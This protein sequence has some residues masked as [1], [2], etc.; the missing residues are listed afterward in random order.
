MIEG[1]SQK[2]TR[3]VPRARA[4]YG[5]GSA[6]RADLRVSEPLLDLRV[7]G[8]MLVPAADSFALS[9]GNAARTIA[10]PTGVHVRTA[11]LTRP[12][13]HPL[14]AADHFADVVTPRALAIFDDFDAHIA[15]LIARLEPLVL[16]DDSAALRSLATCP[17]WCAD[18]TSRSGGAETGYAERSL[19]AVAAMDALHDGCSTME[20]RL[21]GIATTSL[22]HAKKLGM[23]LSL[24]HQ[25]ASVGRWDHA[26][27]AAL[28]VVERERTQEYRVC[29]D[30]I[31]FKSRLTR[32]ELVR[33]VLDGLHARSPELETRP[34]F[35]SF[36]LPTLRAVPETITLSG[37]LELSWPCAPHVPH[38]KLLFA[39]AGLQ[40]VDFQ[41]ATS[42]GPGYITFAL[43]T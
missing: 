38:W 4:G 31:V 9:A 17:Q 35:A 25:H 36:V 14:R 43:P 15:R 23:H 7:H 2:C 19:R 1:P 34:G 40:S 37:S 33:H 27:A 39:L 41:P 32:Y 6:L 8:D 20:R 10:V 12:Y 22:S 18:I 16:S 29:G 5:G 21:L 28:R 42:R 26:R 3:T 30:R 13:L 24:A 11:A